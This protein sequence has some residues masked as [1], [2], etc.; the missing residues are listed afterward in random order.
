MRGIERLRKIKKEE[1]WKRQT[2][3]RVKKVTKRKRRYLQEKE[4]ERGWSLEE[5]RPGKCENKS[6]NPKLSPTV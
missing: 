6:S 2:N 1:D 5:I 3:D 4:K